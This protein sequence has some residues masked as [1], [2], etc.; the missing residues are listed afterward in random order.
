MRYPSID[1]L[2]TIAIFVMVLVHFSENLSGYSFPAAGMGAPLFAFLSG[3]SYLLWSQGRRARGMSELELS[4]ISV[5]R[6]LFVFGVGFAFNVLVWLPED[7]FNWDV[8]TF[9]GLALLLLNGVRRLPLSII[10]LM[11]ILALLVSPIL[12]EMA[13]YNAYWVQRYFDYDMTL[14]DVLIGCLATGYFPIFPWISFSLA[15]FVTASLMFPE[16]DET[17]PDLAPP[18]TTPMIMIGAAFYA[19]SMIAV[20][21]RFYLPTV[22]SKTMLGGWHMFPPTVEYVTG[23]LGVILIVFGLAHQYVDRNPNTARFGG[24]LSIAKTFSRYSFTIYVLHH[25]VHLW[26]LWIY[27]IAQG[28]EPTYYWREAMPISYS[29]PLALFFMVCCYFILRKLGP[30]RTYGIES[31]MRWVCD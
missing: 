21:T 14:S 22:I 4:K 15:G 24:L 31:W 20:F 11:A 19:F 28:Q 27:G 12:R 9:I 1:I 29:I 23:M 3:V 16:A 30:D 7:I 5:R 17:E 10:G 26:P 6:G 2:R 25:L 8:L 13:D 18:S